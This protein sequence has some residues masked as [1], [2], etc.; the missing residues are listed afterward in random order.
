M[1]SCGFVFFFK[2][3]TAYELR[4]SDWSSG[5]CSSDLNAA[6]CKIITDIAIGLQSFSTDSDTLGD[7]YEY[8][9][10]QLAAGSGKKAG[11][12]YT[13]QFVSDILSD[14]VA[15]DGQEPATGKR[16]QL[17]SLLDLAC[18][19]GEML[20]NLSNRNRNRGEEGKSGSVS[21]YC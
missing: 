16:A 15:L 7:A 13:P 1:V 10:G 18:G 12:F 6:L 20:R 19:T 3:K 9:I 21:V 17:A 4:I 14:M 2:Q 11:E 5:V 8:L